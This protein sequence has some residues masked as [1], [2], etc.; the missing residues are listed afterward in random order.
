MR[1]GATSILALHR[2]FVGLR[3]EGGDTLIVGPHDTTP[4]CLLEGLQPGRPGSAF[5]ALFAWTPI[6]ATTLT[7]CVAASIALA[8]SMQ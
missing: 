4:R 3:V 7:E 6:N 1:L 5:L 2:L 8:V